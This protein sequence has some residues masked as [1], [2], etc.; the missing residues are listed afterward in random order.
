MALLERK[1]YLEVPPQVEKNYPEI[2]RNRLKRK[3]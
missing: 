3:L 1:V 2:E